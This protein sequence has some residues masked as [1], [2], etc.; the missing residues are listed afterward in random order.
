MKNFLFILLSGISIFAI[1]NLAYSQIIYDP[2]AMTQT[3]LSGMTGLTRIT[4][5][6][7]GN[8]EPVSFF[9]FQLQPEINLN[10]IGI[11][12]DAVLLYNPDI[13]IRNE[14]G[15]KWNSLGDYL[16][17]IRYF[18]YGR[19]RDSLYFVYGALENMYIGHGL[20]M[21]GYSNYDRR[22]LRFDFNTKV[23][24]A[25]T[26]LNNLAEPSILGGRAYVRP[27]QGSGV[28][29]LI[30]RLTFG[31]TYMT[32][33]DPDP[34]S[35]VDVDPLAAYG[36]D[37]SIPIITDLGLEVYNAF[38]ALRGLAKSPQ[39]PLRKGEVYGTGIGYA[40]GTGMEIFN[41]NFKI[42]YRIF[43]EYFQPTPFDYTYE[44][45][46][47]LVPIAG[48][49]IRKGIYSLLA[50]NLPG[51]IWGA[52]AYEHYNIG[53]PN[54]YGEL[55]EIDLIDEMSLRLF[56]VKHEIE[57]FKDIFD[58]DEKSALTVRIGLEIYPPLELIT[59]HEFRFREREDGKGFEAIRK[60][61][62]E[63]GVNVQF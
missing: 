60:T 38:A 47:P 16:R 12:L 51:K 37:L 29:P 9:R 48:E 5:V 35:N 34:E 41:A 52:V 15:E 61:S 59:L 6:A 32:D 18:R 62:F 19:R 22:G 44:A 55:I 46:K 10:K 43:N 3:G 56:Y 42:E 28:A 21:G 50:Y 39:P 13:G 57:D 25:E 27:F 8:G 7:D 53:D 40:L 23:F 31:A 11:G 30:N 58:L 63:L 33:I 20:I 54:L 49:G 1:N 4:V 26:I 45:S 36:L 14:D 17:A 24:G 2:Y